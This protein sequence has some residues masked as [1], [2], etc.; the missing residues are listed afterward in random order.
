MTETSLTGGYTDEGRHHSVRPL[1]ARLKKTES[2]LP[3]R[4]KFVLN[5]IPG[6][7]SV[8]V[9]LRHDSR[10]ASAGCTQAISADRPCSER[11][12][13]TQLRRLGSSTPG[14]WWSEHYGANY[15]I[16]ALHD[17]SRTFRHS[18]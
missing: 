10:C 17:L 18:Q 4:T 3:Q 12:E 5:R 2:M 13:P 15:R 11:T 8:D 16:G 9:V 6:R 1:R 14:A 7:E